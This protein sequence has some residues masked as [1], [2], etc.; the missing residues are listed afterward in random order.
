MLKCLRK[1]TQLL[2]E[3]QQQPGTSGR[4]HPAD[5]NCKIMSSDA[6]DIPRANRAPPVVAP[7]SKFQNVSVGAQS[8]DVVRTP[9]IHVAPIM[10]L[11][12]PPAG[13]LRGARPDVAG[14]VVYLPYTA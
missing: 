3:H 13:A 12:I 5:R 4:D 7:K 14:R 1:L 6:P 8:G 2:C 11:R 9:R 10:S